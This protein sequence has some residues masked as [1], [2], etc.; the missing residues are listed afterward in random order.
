MVIKSYAKVNLFLKVLNK[1]PDNYH[2]IRT[3]FERI[4]LCDK[5]TIRNRADRLIKIACNHPGVPV[6]ESNLCF[7]AAKLLRDKFGIEKGLDIEISKRIPVG[8]GL[9]GGSSNAASV[10]LALNRLWKL[11]LGREKLAKFAAKIGSDVAFFVYEAPFA[12]G[13]GRGEKI[14]VLR[15]PEKIKLWHVLVAPA[16]RVSTPLI[17]RKFDEL[18]GLTKPDANVKILPSILV[19]RFL[20]SQPGFLSNS[21]E[22]VTLKLYPEV[23]QIKETLCA[24]GA[25]NILMSGSGSAVFAVVSSGRKAAALVKRIKKKKKPWRAYAVSTA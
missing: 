1:R 5:I 25:K 3:L 9:G 14:R 7:K 20:A 8:A 12:V 10:L 21:L 19:G 17:Y 18:C 24:Y 6:D 11:K 16:T 22:Q 15:N 13:Q 2:N 4:S 23:R